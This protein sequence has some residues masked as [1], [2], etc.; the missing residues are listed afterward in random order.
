MSLFFVFANHEHRASLFGV[1][2]EGLVTVLVSLSVAGCRGPALFDS[3][4]QSD[5]VNL[6]TA[7]A[8]TYPCENVVLSDATGQQTGV[9]IFREHHCLSFQPA[10]TA[11]FP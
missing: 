6:G 10:A 3:Q 11:T 7:S 8:P 9:P 2:A 1:H 4:L 5:I